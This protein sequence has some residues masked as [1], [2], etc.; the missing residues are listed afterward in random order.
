[1]FFVRRTTAA[2]FTNVAARA[3]VGSKCVQ[4]RGLNVGTGS[5]GPAVPAASPTDRKR[6]TCFSSCPLPPFE[7]V[8]KAPRQFLEEMKKSGSEYITLP[9]SQ[10][11]SRPPCCCSC[12]PYHL[13]VRYHRIK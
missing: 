2:A 1:M 13:G 5:A 11:A 9:A 12:P 7:F 3:I 8:V 10:A 6:C 4:L